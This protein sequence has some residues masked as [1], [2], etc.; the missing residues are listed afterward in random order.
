MTPRKRL[1]ALAAIALAATT[2]SAAVSAP[3]SARPQVECEVEGD[4][5]EC[6]LAYPYQSGERWYLDG[7]H[8]PNFNGD[9]SAFGSCDPGRHYIRATWDGGRSSNDF[10]CS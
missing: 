3:A 8:L 1:A 10:T 7:V 5:W 6:Y 4:F 2:L 9:S